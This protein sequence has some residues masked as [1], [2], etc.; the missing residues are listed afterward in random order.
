[1]A[2]LLTLFLLGFPSHL[3][4]SKQWL[5][6]QAYKD[7]SSGNCCRFARHSLLF[8]YRNHKTGAKLLLFIDIKIEK[9]KDA[10]INNPGQSGK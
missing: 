9:Q 8:L 3:F 10:V 5:I 1:M 2:G 4:C 7:Y 6:N